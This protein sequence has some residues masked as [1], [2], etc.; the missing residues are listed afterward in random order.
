[1]D[2]SAEIKGISYT[3]H[4]CSSLKTFAFADLEQAFSN[5]TFILDIDHLNRVAISQW[6]SP[7]RTRSYPYARVYDTLEFSGKKI[8]VIPVIKDEGKRGDRDFLQWD[9]ISLMSLLNVHVI[10]GYYVD[11]EDNTRFPN[12]KI[13]RQ[14]FDIPHV[15]STIEEIL[16][17][18]SS[19]LHWNL[20]QAGQVGEIAQK[21]LES[22][23][24]ISKRLNVEMHSRES[25]Q[26][27]ITQL[28]EGREAFMSLSREL[29][30]A[31]QRRETVT[32]QPKEQVSG[33]KGNITI[34]NFQGGYYYL[35][36]DEVEI[37]GQ[38][39]HLIEAKHS[40]RSMLPSPNDI[41]DALIKMFLFTNLEDV[42]VEGQT[43][44]PVP[45][46]KLTGGIPFDQDA[47]RLA[48]R[49]FWE[50]LNEKEAENGFVIRV[51]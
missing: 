41:K 4:L 24:E 40:R 33:V 42:Q 37:T 11:A 45:I 9:T 47:L 49:R 51:G 3:P 14:R 27:R 29:A 44:N 32:L 6:V 18:Q 25:A 2:L 23:S 1:M 36:L 46:M 19:P 43:Y 30:E 38:D 16:S 15:K 21:A 7:K 35:T 12:E 34:K 5:S 17:Y 48:Q 8:T 28:Q 20:K 13:T 39:I 22:Y 10:I 31:A 50:T 26:R